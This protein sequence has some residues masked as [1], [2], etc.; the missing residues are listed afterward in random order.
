M[1]IVACQ[2]RVLEV[3]CVR[4]GTSHCGGLF[5]QAILNT[6]QSHSYKHYSVPQAFEP[7]C[8]YRM[9]ILYLLLRNNFWHIFSE[10]L[11]AYLECLLYTQSTEGENTQLVGGI[12]Q[13]PL[14]RETQSPQASTLVT[15]GSEVCGVEEERGGF[16]YMS[17]MENVVV[18]TFEFPVRSATVVSHVCHWFMHNT[19][20]SRPV[21]ES[22]SIPTL[23]GFY[24]GRFP[25]CHMTMNLPVDITLL[26]CVF[27]QWQA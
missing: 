19:S 8:F 7:W 10:S 1:C 15:S 26:L 12:Y 17:C 9:A 22:E 6:L 4:Q 20:D 25:C 3:L 21:P 16:N 18:K 11:H 2:C 13:P 24:T 14:L 5:I 23:L 27:L